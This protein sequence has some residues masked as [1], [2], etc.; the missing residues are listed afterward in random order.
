MRVPEAP[1]GGWGE[2]GLCPEGEQDLVI[3]NVSEEKENKNGQMFYTV[4]FKRAGGAPDEDAIFQYVPVGG[5]TQ[6]E[7]LLAMNI[8]PEENA[9]TEFTLKDRVVNATIWHNEKATD[10]SGATVTKAQIRKFNRR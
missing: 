3:K 5:V 6:R 10:A 4:T 9:N 1:A 2:L 7:L 8:D